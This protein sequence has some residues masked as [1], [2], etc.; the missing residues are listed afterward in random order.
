MNFE[1]TQPG[2][3]NNRNL[4]LLFLFAVLGVLVSLGTYA[5][6]GGFERISLGSMVAVIVLIVPVTI[7]VM[8]GVSQGI[9]YFSDLRAAWTW[10]HWLFL[11]LTFSTLVFRQRDNRSEEH[12]SELQSP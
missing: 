12:T 2:L 8:A 5:V 9:R 10:W 6:A 1:T 7:L 4:A 3:A 11:L